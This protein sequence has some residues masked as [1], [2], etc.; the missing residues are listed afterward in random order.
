MSVR[1]RVSSEALPIVGANA[2]N[3]YRFALPIPQATLQTLRYALMRVGFA[4]I[5]SHSFQRCAAFPAFRICC[6]NTRLGLCA[7]ARL[8]L[9]CEK[10]A[11]KF[12]SGLAKVGGGSTFAPQ[13]VVA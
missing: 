1:V 4:E 7:D 8:T 5:Y 6:A 2:P 9:S 11:T 12:V 13:I 3:P 10:S